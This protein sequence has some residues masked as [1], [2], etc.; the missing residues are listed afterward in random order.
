MDNDYSKKYIKY[1]N[2]Y[3]ILKNNVLIG[4]GP[5]LLFSPRRIIDP[6]SQS[7][8]G[9]SKNSYDIYFPKL[10]DIIRERMKNITDIIQQRIIIEKVNN[11]IIGKIGARNLFM[12]TFFDSMFFFIRL[13]IIKGLIQRLKEA[14]ELYTTLETTYNDSYNK[15]KA[16]SSILSFSNCKKLNI[17]KSI[18]FKEFIEF[19]QIVDSYNSYKLFIMNYLNTIKK[20]G[21]KI[22]KFIVETNS[23]DKSL[24]DDS[25]MMYAK[26]NYFTSLSSIVDYILKSDKNVSDVKEL[27]NPIYDSSIQYTIDQIVIISQIYNFYN[28]LEPFFKEHM[29]EYY[30]DE[31]L[32]IIKILSSV[33]VS[34]NIKT[35]VS[36]ISEIINIRNSILSEK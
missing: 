2:K 8:S 5:P 1:K 18:H 21:D 23:I 31:N 14:K 7:S 19:T 10:S 29:I 3:N 28:D 24:V 33:E 34:E 4:N 20:D 12:K 27:I 9:Q 6:R 26:V 13:E 16:K 11:G 35:L 22:S 15:C 17:T 30:S 25:R 36:L 32:E